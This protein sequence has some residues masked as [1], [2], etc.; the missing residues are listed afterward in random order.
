M[1]VVGV[2]HVWGLSEQAWSGSVRGAEYG[3]ARRKLSRRATLKPG[4]VE[5]WVKLGLDVVFQ[6]GGVEGSLAVLWV[7]RQ[8]LCEVRWKI[9]CWRN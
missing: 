6:D 9:K 7:G 1:A 2:E 8:Y 5:D 4:Q 3:G